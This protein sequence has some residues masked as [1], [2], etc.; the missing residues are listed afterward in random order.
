MRNPQHPSKEP[1][2]LSGPQPDVDEGSDPAQPP[3]ARLAHRGL[4]A[5]H[6]A[7][8]QSAEKIRRTG[9]RV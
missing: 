1:D 5:I 6:D 4:E 8:G 7:Q 9:L 2:G 3:I